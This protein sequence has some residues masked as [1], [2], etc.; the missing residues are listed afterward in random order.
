MASGVAQQIVNES[1][2]LRRT[3]RHQKYKNTNS[4]VEVPHANSLFFLNTAHFFCS[5]LV[6]LHEE[7]PQSCVTRRDDKSQW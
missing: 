2:E 1:Q 4:K 7:E 6:F 3:P 5:F